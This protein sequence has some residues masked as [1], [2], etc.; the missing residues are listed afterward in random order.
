MNKTVKFI[1]VG[2]WFKCYG[3][4]AKVVSFLTNF[5]LF[6]DN[7]TMKPT[8]G[9][10][11]ESIDKVIAKLKTY[12]VNYMID[13]SEIHDFGKENNYDRFLYNNLPF[14]YVVR[15]N[16]VNKKI[17]GCF[18]VKYESEPDCEEFIINDTISQDAELTKKVLSSVVGETIIIND[19]KIKIIEKNIEQ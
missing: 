12:K 17:S 18:K 6:E 16:T 3:D 10:P 13:N 8:V 7:K 5:K 11:I 4:D 1:Q 14:S 9:F 19:E 2:Y 15:E